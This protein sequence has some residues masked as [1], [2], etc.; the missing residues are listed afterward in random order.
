MFSKKNGQEKDYHGHIEN[1]VNK[2]PRLFQKYRNYIKKY[3]YFIVPIHFLTSAL[4]LFLIHTMIN[5]NVKIRETVQK[6][7]KNDSQM[8]VRGNVTKEVAFILAIYKLISPI[9]FG[10]TIL[11]THTVAKLLKKK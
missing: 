3:G 7:T 2:N 11:I 4:W 6:W 10:S 9:R 5:S 1:E 8:N